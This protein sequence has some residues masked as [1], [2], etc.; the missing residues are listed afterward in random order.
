MLDDVIHDMLLVVARAKIAPGGDRRMEHLL[1]L[2]QHVLDFRK[3]TPD[4]QA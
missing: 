3:E 1:R 2:E 4:A